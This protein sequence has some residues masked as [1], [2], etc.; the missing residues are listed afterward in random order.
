MCKDIADEG[1][2]WI[3][4]VSAGL[5]GGK[6]GRGLGDWLHAGIVLSLNGSFN[7][8]GVDSGE[9][10]MWERKRERARETDK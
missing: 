1:E 6:A 8:G 10:E 7:M 4:G 5:G 3:W 2:E 9:D